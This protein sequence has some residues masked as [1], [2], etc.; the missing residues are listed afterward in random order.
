MNIKVNQIKSQICQEQA[1][2]N[3]K[4]GIRF[5]LNIRE[6]TIGKA[7]KNELIVVIFIF[8]RFFFSCRACAKQCVAMGA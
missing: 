4:S 2:S 6:S 3:T 1:Y 8:H 5:F 7:T